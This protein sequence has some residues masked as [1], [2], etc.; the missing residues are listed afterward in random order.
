MV[1]Y[2]CELAI[3]KKTAAL[4]NIEHHL[5]SIYLII[6]KTRCPGGKSVA[7]FKERKAGDV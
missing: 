3:L 1:A 7:H 2:N 5:W 4:A 6:N